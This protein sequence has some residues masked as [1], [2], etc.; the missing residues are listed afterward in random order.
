MFVGAIVIALYAAIVLLVNRIYDRNTSVLIKKAIYGD[1][2]PG[3]VL[4]KYDIHMGRVYSE[5]EYKS[6]GQI[7]GVR[8]Y[9]QRNTALLIYY[10]TSDKTY[11]AK[12]MH[13]ICIIDSGSIFP[14]EY[15]LFYD[16][17]KMATHIEMSNEAIHRRT[18]ALGSEN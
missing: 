4:E 15:W 8:L 14:G 3:G 5:S 13:S 12:I 16:M 11:D 1:A 10:T 17:K 7:Y 18:G 9:S 2:K 6:G